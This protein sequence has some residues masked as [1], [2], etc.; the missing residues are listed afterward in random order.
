MH[1]D[2]DDDDL[3][4]TTQ[5]FVGKL[6]ASARRFADAAGADSAIVRE[7]VPPARHRRARCRVVF[8]YEAGREADVTFLGPASSL[9][10]EESPT[11][12]FDTAI[13]LWLRARQDRS[14]RW[15]P[16]DEEPADAGAVDV[17]ASL[18]R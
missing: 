6:R 8:L 11:S 12:Q 1:H 14:R 9:A 4:T 16:P 2:L 10:G 15:L 5:I 17:P 3:A 13:E 18:T 7:A